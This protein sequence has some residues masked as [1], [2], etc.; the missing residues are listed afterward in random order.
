MRSIFTV[1][2]FEFSFKADTSPYPISSAKIKTIFGICSS[3]PWRA[4]PFK[5]TKLP[6][7]NKT[8]L[9]IIDFFIL[10]IIY[11]P[12]SESTPHYFY[13]F[14][15]EESAINK[16]VPQKPTCT[17][18][19]YI[20]QLANILTDSDIKSP[21]KTKIRSNTFILFRHEKIR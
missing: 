4:N 11:N 20:Q 12:D 14:R 3:C 10:Y 21:Q 1:C 9:F 16:S 13:Q 17:K 7:D 18:V 2:N 15:F 8:P 5:A 6:N 19:M